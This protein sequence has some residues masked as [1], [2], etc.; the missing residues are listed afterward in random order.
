MTQERLAQL[1]GV[2]LGTIQGTEQGKTSPRYETAEKIDSAL[3]ADGAILEAFG[4]VNRQASPAPV[5]QPDDELV[6]LVSELTQSVEDILA[7]AIDQRQKLADLESRLAALE[8]RSG[9]RSA[10]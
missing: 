10:D 8:G 4:Y 3:D 1:V 7:D 9:R 2:S 5:T 6:V